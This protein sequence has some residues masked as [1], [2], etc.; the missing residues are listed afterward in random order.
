MTGKVD[1]NE[2]KMFYLTLWKDNMAGR[3]LM[4]WAYQACMK[5]TWVHYPPLQLLPTVQE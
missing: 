4:D 1:Q 2:G 3:E 5:E